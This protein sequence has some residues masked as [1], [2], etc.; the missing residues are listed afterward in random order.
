MATE[1][2]FF[3][4]IMVALAFRACSFFKQTEGR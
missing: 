4:I 2:A 3:G 1:A